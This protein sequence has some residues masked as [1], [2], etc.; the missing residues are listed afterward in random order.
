[1]SEAQARRASKKTL[2]EWC[3]GQLVFA[4]TQRS[5]PLAGPAGDW[6]TVCQLGDAWTGKP[7]DKGRIASTPMLDRFGKVNKLR[8][9]AGAAIDRWTLEAHVYKVTTRGDAAPVFGDLDVAAVTS[10]DIAKVMGAQP[11]EHRA[12]T[13]VKMYNRLHRLFE[14]AEFPCRLRPEGTN[15][16]KKY[17]RPAP[18]ADKLFC[19]LYP[20]ELLALLRGRNAAGEVGVP[21]PRRVL[22][23][24]AVY[25]GQRKGSLF[26][27]QW[28]HADFDHGTLAS[29]KTKTG[30]AQY[31][32]A[33]RGLMAL[34]L[35]WQAHEGKPGGDT[36][37]VP[38]AI[39]RLGCEPKRLATALRDDLAAVGVTRRSSSRRTKL[40]SSR[41]ASTTC[42][43]RSARGRAG[44]G[45]PTR[46]S[47]SGPVRRSPAI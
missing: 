13:R 41:Y 44:Q 33:D 39:E 27:M 7:D 14:L 15:P 43:R 2:A 20:S 17:L 12:E 35:A 11:A 4:P 8:L 3:A 18:D 42:A 47:P 26:A 31:F 40:T 36:A 34:L 38:S 16:V 24:L 29:F 45:S 6:R 1:M 9:K 30:R 28:K 22:Y 46:G 37:I 32:V 5:A 10:D 19:F 25:T 23:A 21:L